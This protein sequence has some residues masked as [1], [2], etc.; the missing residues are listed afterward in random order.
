MKT[1]IC[2]RPGQLPFAERAIPIAGP[3]DVLIRIRRGGNKAL[4][5]C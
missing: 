5:A 2:E 3:D 1:V 4:V